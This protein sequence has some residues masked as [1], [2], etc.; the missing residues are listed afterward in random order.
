MRLDTLEK[1]KEAMH[2]YEALGFQK[3]D[4][5]YENPL[6]GV[7]YWELELKKEMNG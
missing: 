7:V 3:T 1:L 2:L 5:Y 4:P 6:V